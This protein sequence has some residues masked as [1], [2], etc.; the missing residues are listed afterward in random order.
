MGGK[1]WGLAVGLFV[2][3]GNRYSWLM[4]IY[5]LFIQSQMVAKPF[6]GQPVLTYL[7]SMNYLCSVIYWWSRSYMAHHYHEQCLLVPEGTDTDLTYNKLRQRQRLSMC[8]YWC[9]WVYVFL[10]VN[11]ITEKNVQTVF[12]K[13]WRYVGPHHRLFL[14]N[15]FLIFWF[16]FRFIFH[17][18]GGAH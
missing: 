16:R 11:N 4:L 8:L 5:H 10:C 6:A 3:T 9:T 17:Q 15:F 18:G 13:F 2:Y 1:G 12:N 7:F 14:L